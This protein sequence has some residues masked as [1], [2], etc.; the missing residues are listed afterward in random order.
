M[1]QG[2]RQE[3]TPEEEAAGLIARKK[4]E[5]E[6]SQADERALMATLGGAAF[7]ILGF[8]VCGVGL[9]AFRDIM[10]GTFGAGIGL[11][12]FGVITA[13]QWSKMRGGNGA[14]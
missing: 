3:R 10:I 14:D 9:L 12:G 8:V 13:A 2:T 4:A 7:G 1:T 5:A 6:A 11:V